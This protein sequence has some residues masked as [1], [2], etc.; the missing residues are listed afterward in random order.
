LPAR[1]YRGMAERTI[2]TAAA[3]RTAAQVVVEENLPGIA[4]VDAAIGAKYEIHLEGEFE[5]AFATGALKGDAIYINKGTFAL[6]RVAA[7]VAPGAGVGILFA[8]VTGVPGNGADANNVEPKAG[9]M[10]VKLVGFIH[11]DVPA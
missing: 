10:W 9:K 1:N 7:N 6:S 11:N 5:L 4:A 8:K 2:V 3:A